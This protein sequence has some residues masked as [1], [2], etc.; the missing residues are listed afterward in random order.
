MADQEIDFSFIEEVGKKVNDYFLNDPNHSEWFSTILDEYNLNNEYPP[1]LISIIIEKLTS[2]NDDYCPQ[3]LNEVQSIIQDEDNIDNLLSFALTTFN[4]EEEESNDNDNDNEDKSTPAFSVESQSYD[5]DDDDL[6]SDTT[7]SKEYFINCIKKIMKLLCISY[8]ISYV[9]CKKYKFNKDI[10]LQKWFSSQAEVLQSLRIKIGSK[11][12]PDLKSPLLIKKYGVGECPICY[13]ETEL[14]E[15]YCGHIICEECLV[16]DI[17]QMISEKITPCCRQ[18]NDDENENCGALIIFE[19]TK[20]FLREDKELIENFSQIVFKNEVNTSPN[21]KQCPFEFCDGVITPMNEMPCHVG[22]CPKCFSAVCLRCHNDCHG[23]FSSCSSIKSYFEQADKME[24]LADKQKEWLESNRKEVS[25]DQCSIHLCYKKDIENLK[26]EI[27]KKNNENK[28]QITNLSNEIRKLQ[29]RIENL[30]FKKES[31]NEEEIQKLQ[32]ELNDKKIIHEK[33][34][35]E[36]NIN[37]EILKNKHVE[38]LMEEDC[39]V[40][41]LSFPER[42]NNIIFNYEIEMDLLTL[43]KINVSYKDEIMNI[44]RKRLKQILPFNKRG[45]NIINGEVEEEEEKNENYFGMNSEKDQKNFASEKFID[46][47]YTR[48]PKCQTPIEKTE[49]CN[50][51]YC[52]ICGTNFDYGTGQAY[53]S[54]TPIQQSISHLNH[55]PIT[56]DKRASF[57]KWTYLYSKFINEKQ[58]YNNLFAEVK[59]T[60]NKKVDPGVVG[61]PD[62]FLCLRNKIAKALLIN[63][64]KSEIKMKTYRIMNIA[65]FAQSVLMWSYPTMFY[66]RN[67]DDEKET[68]FEY[69]VNCL[70]ESLNK[71]IKLIN[72]PTHST[73]NDFETFIEILLK[74]IKD[75]LTMAESL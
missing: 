66:I 28:K 31:K 30:T 13:E 68:L 11:M 60:K 56:Y 75:L 33:I 39:L 29:Y 19:S 36:I 25:I 32:K 72:D 64:A 5:N 50:H 14:F 44:E 41:A 57:L 34:N 40:S 62:S 46:L 24:K 38:L 70:H 52:T 37:N 63:T 6:I 18:I 15:L 71:Y 42:Y 65:L 16:S 21:A 47:N 53:E 23:P 35:N 9:L 55:D 2:A 43:R 27:K 59:S 22:L 17:R 12:V 45:I 10:I 8:D 54:S 20:D 49:G 69:K 3:L 58:N 4:E 1:D 73:S 74:Q 51:M 61:V 7:D 67:D 26:E 48:C